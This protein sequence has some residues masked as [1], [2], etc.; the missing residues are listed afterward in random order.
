MTHARFL[1]RRLLQAIP[2]VIGVTLVVFLLISALNPGFLKPMLES[3]IGPW[4]LWGAVVSVILGYS[5]MMKIAD[6][7]MRPT[8]AV[9]ERG[10]TGTSVSWA[11]GSYGRPQV[12]RSA[13][14]ACM[15]DVRAYGVR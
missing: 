13:I 6:I 1:A 11:T 2:V 9:P 3:S 15:P 12:K 5:W 8:S 4:F 10:T 14:E 7:R